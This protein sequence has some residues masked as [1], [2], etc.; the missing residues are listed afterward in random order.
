MKLTDEEINNAAENAQTIQ[1]SDRGVRD[2]NFMRGARWAESKYL[3]FVEAQ[4][5]ILIDTPEKK[6][7]CLP[8]QVDDEC[9]QFDGRGWRLI[10]RNDGEFYPHYIY[11]RRIAWNKVSETPIP[12]G[13]PVWGFSSGLS[14]GVSL[15]FDGANGTSYTTHWRYASIP[16]PPID[17]ERVE[18]EKWLTSESPEWRTKGVSQIIENLWACWQAARSRKQE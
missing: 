6:K 11:R 10:G 9:F 15:Y 14:S 1:V 8:P 17:P 18:F 12:K 13:V 7:A 2:L 3:P 5:W 4:E 16:T